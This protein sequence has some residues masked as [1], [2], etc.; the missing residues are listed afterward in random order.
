MAVARLRLELHNQKLLDSL[1]L[2]E[3]QRVIFAVRIADIRRE[4]GGGFL[5]RFDPDS[6][7]LLTDV[8]AGI[9]S[10]IPEAAFRTLMEQ[11]QTWAADLP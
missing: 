4:D 6:A 3:P 7:V 5:A 1:P 8:S 11:Q 9:L 10:D 2:E